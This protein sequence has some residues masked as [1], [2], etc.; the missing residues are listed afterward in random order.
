MKHE[1]FSKQVNFESQ[2]EYSIL[3]GA[4]FVPTESNRYIFTKGENEELLGKE[5]DNLFRRSDLNILNLEVPI[6]N[7][8]DELS[9]EGSPNL[10][11]YSEILNILNK[12]SAVL[13]SGANNHIYDYKQKGIEDTLSYLDCSGINH[14]GFGLN[15]QEARKA[16]FKKF[17]GLTIGV[18]SCSENEF[19]CANMNHGGGNGY[20]PLDTFDDI[21]VAKKMCDYLIVLHHGGRENYRYPTPELKRVCIKMADSGADLVVCQHS[22][23]IGTYEIHNDSLI[24]YGQ[25]NL[26]FDYNELEEWKTSILVEVN[27][28][29]NTVKCYAI[30]IEKC[31]EKVRASEELG[32]DIILQ[33]E[34]RS[35]K[36]S[37]WEF[38]KR[39]Y[40]EFCLNQ[41]NILLLRGVMGV[42]SKIL[43]AI[44]KVSRGKLLNLFFGKRHRLL[45]INYIR[46]ES[47][48][49]AILDILNEET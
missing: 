29:K 23:C 45:L 7:S 33:M 44:N 18:Y 42:N 49:E 22:H 6:T 16:W 41:K 30:P 9:K 31:G 47:I 15:K 48:R 5:L 20:D 39:Q 8:N 11:T 27:I 12:M 2:N 32:Q 4:D 34:N 10:K 37:D 19:C 1:L 26:L 35:A 3:I 21:N 43:W 25:G 46:C 40:H 38:L 36:I 24:V 14:V 17:E 28:H 13:L